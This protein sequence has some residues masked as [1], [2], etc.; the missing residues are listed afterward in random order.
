V[1][2]TPAPATLALPPPPEDPVV[3]PNFIDVVEP[4]A[5][6]PADDPWA[7]FSTKK[8]KKKK[9]SKAAASP[10]FEEVPLTKTKSKDSKT[11]PDDILAIVDEAPPPPEP[12]PEP[13]PVKEEKKEEKKSSKASS[14]GWGSLWGSSGG[15]KAKSSKEKEKEAAEKAEKEAAEE[16][17]KKADAEAF[18]AALGDDPDDI[19]EIVE[20]APKKPSSSK[21][22]GSDKLKKVDS[23]SSK[24]S[25]PKDDPI[26]AVVDDPPAEADPVLDFLA[27]DPAKKLDT[28]PSAAGW[29]FWGA[30]LKSSKKATPGAAEAKKEIGDALTNPLPELTADAKMPE[31]T[32]GDD[33]ELKS[34][35]LS[36]LPKAA[37]KSSS[38]KGSSIQDRIKALQ[39]D[40]ADATPA[41]KSKSK[42]KD[43][44]PPPPPPPAESVPEPEPE[45]VAEPEPVVVIPP[46]PEEKKSKKKSK[47]SKE[48]DPPSADPII[49]APLSPPSP[50]PGG[51]PEDEPILDVP[52]PVVEDMPPVT[53][54]SSSK[55]KKSSKSTK[56]SA[57][58][59]PVPE[60]EPVVEAPPPPPPA[61]F[62]DLV[63]LD[64]PPAAPEALTPPP[65]KSSK[66][67]DA[68]RGHKKE[69]PKVM[70]DQGSNSWG[71]WGATP[72]PKSS[73]KKESRSKESA[74]SPV[75]ERP[76][77]LTRSKSARKPSEKD[78]LEKASK[79]SGSDKDG[80]KGASTSKSR[81]STSRGMG[82]FGMGAPTPS[83]SKST[84][85]RPSTSRRHSTAVIDS[86][87]ISPPPE[88][89]KEMSAK[90]AKVMGVS[91]SKST[92]EKKTR[93]I[94]DPYAIDSDD[95]IVV[96]ALEAGDSAK[97]VPP[98]EPKK[99]KSRRHKRESTMMSG[100]LGEDAVMVDAPRGSD[101][102]VDDLAFD[103]RPPLVR[104]A[105]SS[106]KKPGLMGG[107]L[108]AFGSSRP[109]PDRR[110][111]KAYESEDGMSRRKRSSAYDEDTSKRLRREDRKVNRSRK[112][113]DPDG[114]VDAAA[115][116]EDD[117]AREARRAE[118]RARRDREAAEEEARAARRKDREEARAAKAREEEDRLRRLE[119]EREQRKQDERRARRAER[120]ARRAEEERIAQEEEAKAAERRERRRERERQRMEEEYA[121]RPKMP[122]D[123]RRSH[124][125][126]P[127]TDDEEAR[128]IRREERRQ[129]RSVDQG[130]P[131]YDRDKPRTSR[132]RSDYPAPVEDYFDKRNGEHSPY[133]ANVVA[134][135]PIEADGRPY[136][137]TS[138]GDKTASWVHSVNEDPPPPPPVEGTIIDAPV[139]FAEDLAPDAL[140]ETT[141]REY[142]KRRDRDRERDRDG[143]S[144]EDSERR[145]RRRDEKRGMTGEY[146]KS[147]SGGSSHD[148]RKSYAGGPVNSLGL[149][150]MGG[151]TFDGRPAPGGKR[152]STGWF[153]KF[154]GL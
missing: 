38:K 109:T 83:R 134:T 1:L 44:T 34:A 82:L 6:P 72:P 70:R 133:K 62:D 9:G 129:R 120:E 48:S 36:P 74:S 146:V 49:E 93:K 7:T 140:D 22:K 5:E 87:L 89:S 117:A 26:V 154:T 126:R 61:A 40:S 18:A 8:D 60:P 20:E 108:G 142:R 84:R 45:P 124:M 55:D 153:K 43:A 91:R 67:K 119:E 139:H 78:P 25:E 75:K 53:K 79:S 151:K 115:E 152:G 59:E 77:G 58:A 80:S 4:P 114:F 54:K 130:G 3:E 128:R 96:D 65:K 106:A 121:P 69:R 113:S 66:D 85:D 150:E 29:G 23:K 105:T 39:G 112:P 47:K 137:K 19:L 141:A 21:K 24:K 27:D 16:A 15:S 127:A 99:E 92:R 149:N 76:A 63:G 107:F 123:R 41:K 42:D 132:W 118:R 94:P 32:W 57:K 2:Q 51:F 131:G 103:V 11:S 13:V 30:S 81:P 111:S 95:M 68:S 101:D 125:D 31:F 144:Y 138:G 110:Q 46:S 50:I 52:P 37:S 135:A 143:Y 90:A 136:Q 14:S 56:K 100:G 64:D 35:S 97:D 98:A 88:D 86:G 10:V 73:S 102:K 148:R 147:S 145:R 122:S 104:R 17:Q 28:T 33:A 12:E 116:A 71:F